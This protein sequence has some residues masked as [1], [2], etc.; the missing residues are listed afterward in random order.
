[1]GLPNIAITFTQIASTAIER[2]E[3]GIVLLLLTDSTKTGNATY[4]SPAEVTTEDWN[5]SNVG[6]IKEAFLGGAAKVVCVRKAENTLTDGTLN[7]YDF[8]WMASPVSG[9]QNGIV[10]YVKARNAESAGK[11][12]KAVV[13][14]QTADDIHIV[15]FAN[16]KV[17][18][19]DQAQADGVTYCPRIAGILA[20]LPFTRSATFY[21]LD[22]IESVVEPEDVD[23]AIDGGQFVII[24]DFGE[25]KVGRAV[26]SKTTLS[27]TE[28]ESIKHI[29][30]V[31]AMDL[32]QED[33]Y[34]TFKKT[35]VGKYKNKY[36]N[37]CLFLS[38]INQYFDALTRDDILDP[39]YDNHAEIDVEAQR[40]A[41]IEAGTDASG[42]DEITV[43]KNTFR[44]N[45]YLTGNVKILDAIEDMKF[46]ISLA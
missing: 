14:N 4:T 26:N 10:T 13:F 44:T 17:T 28:N 2:S 39:E 32:M 8:N 41:W 46:V 5:A 11:K 23:A 43:K 37:Q 3:R 45:L 7:A 16:S 15:N 20:G 24:N 33:I 38:A 29:T 19:K 27:T 1:M 18:R 21:E 36:S 9:D 30:V 42:W 12:I 22:D 31:E 6:Y 35:Y 34:S 40:Q 25:P